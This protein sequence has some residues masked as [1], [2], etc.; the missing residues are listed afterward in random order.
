MV[1]I[2]VFHLAM[3]SH[4]EYNMTE[5]IYLHWVS[6]CLW[7][8]LDQSRLAPSLKLNFPTAARAELRFPP[9]ISASLSSPD[10]IKAQWNASHAKGHTLRGFLIKIGK[11]RARPHYSGCRF[12][13]HSTHTFTSLA[14][15]SHSLLLHS[16]ATTHWSMNARS[17]QE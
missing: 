12:P 5:P 17:V 2:R 7:S 9:I 14:H 8:I 6:I 13:Q 10:C 3:S 11:N 4:L 15:I 16:L 1:I